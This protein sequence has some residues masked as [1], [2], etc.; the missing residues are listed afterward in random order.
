MINLI[1]E[2]HEC[3]QGG[4]DFV[5]CI[6]LLDGQRFFATEDIDQ[7]LR[8]PDTLFTEDDVTVILDW[9]RNS[10]EAPFLG[11]RMDVD[12]GGALY[13]HRVGEI[14]YLENEDSRGGRKMVASL[15]LS[16][17]TKIVSDLG[18][19]FA[20]IHQHSHT[21]NDAEQDAASNGD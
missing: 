20:K 21:Q 11:P 12:F 18:A 15:L 7:I 1:Q 4:G 10:C 17:W 6:A 5:A 16:E 8:S 14:L 9:D 13:L 19:E 3:V 2:T